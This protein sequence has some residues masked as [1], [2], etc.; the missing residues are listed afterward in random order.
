[1]VKVAFVFHGKIGSNKLG[2]SWE[3]SGGEADVIAKSYLS[4][5][6]HV[7]NN[8]DI[9]VPSQGHRKIGLKG[10]IIKCGGRELS[11]YVSPAIHFLIVPINPPNP[12]TGL[13]HSK[14]K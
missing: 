6:K 12:L 10:L 11:V 8:N 4:F 9:D 13:R 7:L 2:K 1:M 14:K 3:N 5:R